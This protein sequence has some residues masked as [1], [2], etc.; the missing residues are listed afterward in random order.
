MG[1]PRASVSHGTTTITFHTARS[2][3]ARRMRLRGMELRVQQIPPAGSHDV[4]TMASHAANQA[5]E[6][7]I[8]RVCATTTLLATSAEPYTPQ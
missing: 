4:C 3:S 6:S 1:L 2:R 5:P 7:C 8:W